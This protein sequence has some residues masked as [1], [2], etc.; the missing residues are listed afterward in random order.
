MV[1]SSG[2]SSSPYTSGS[3]SQWGS[4]VPAPG[5]A[6]SASGAPSQGQSSSGAGAGSPYT[7]ASAWG[8]SAPSATGSGSASAWGSPA[9]S[10]AG[11]APASTSSPTGTS[12]GM[13]SGSSA[14]G[15]APVPPQSSAPSPGAPAAGTAAPA[16]ASTS[17]TPI[18]FT[19]LAIGL[20]SSLMLWPMSVWTWGAL[21]LGGQ[22]VPRGGF[23][24]YWEYNSARGFLYC[25][26]AFC[27]FVVA[28]L[29]IKYTKVLTGGMKLRTM[30]CYCISGLVI[31]ALF[32]SS[33]PYSQLLPI[34]KSDIASNM[35]LGIV[36]MLLV[37]C[38]AGLCS[39]S[40]HVGSKAGKIAGYI[41]SGVALLLAMLLISGWIISLVS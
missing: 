28:Y 18:S 13:P 33:S 3:A 5:S 20:L 23:S 32:G 36:P 27:A 17:I 39:L 22:N 9:P 7:S 40:D 14:W 25:F 6:G 21:F 4:P 35:F 11:G 31:L 12:S 30:V 41:G 1:N 19:A 29:T 34:H 26:I 15:A 2:G 38:G 10:S 8:S 24:L 16:A 37:F